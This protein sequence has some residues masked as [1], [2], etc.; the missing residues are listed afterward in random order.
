LLLAPTLSAS[1]SITQRR[2]TPFADIGISNQSK[3]S[4]SLNSIPISKSQTVSSMDS[5]V[6]SNTNNSKTQSIQSVGSLSS[7][8]DIV[9]NA[10]T[11]GHLSAPSKQMQRPASGTTLSS[12]DLNH[13]SP[14]SM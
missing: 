10:M 9:K 7:L 13:L 6:M 4:S 12:K 8:T 11:K 2:W 14:Q 1:S 5:S 3:P